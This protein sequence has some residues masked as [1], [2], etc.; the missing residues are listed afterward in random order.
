ME[1]QQNNNGRAAAGPP[2]AFIGAQFAVMTA[3]QI[4]ESLARDAQ[5]QAKGNLAAGPLFRVTADNFRAWAKVAEPGSMFQAPEVGLKIIRLSAFAPLATSLS[6]EAQQRV[7]EPEE[8]S[9][10]DRPRLFRP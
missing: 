9:P 8:L 3:S 4:L 7:E 5:V 10:N 1:K 6:P 2:F